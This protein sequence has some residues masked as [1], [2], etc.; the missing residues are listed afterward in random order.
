MKTMTRAAAVE[1]V[2]EIEV[3]VIRSDSENLESI[4]RDGFKAVVERSNEQLAETIE[5]ADGE[6]VEIE[7]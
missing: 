3:E 6:P 2:I 5:Y 4:V 7:G 1:R